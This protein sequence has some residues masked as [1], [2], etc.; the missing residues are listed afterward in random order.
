MCTYI[1]NRA[2]ISGSGK[3]GAGWVQLDQLTVSF[4]HPVSAQ[5]G[6][7]FLID[8]QGLADVSGNRI[9]LELD[10]ASATAL[11]ELLQQTIE[12]AHSTGLTE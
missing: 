10:V 7:G 11:V 3:A 12:S 2:A 8:F 1:M 4:D 5:L 9:G 6:H